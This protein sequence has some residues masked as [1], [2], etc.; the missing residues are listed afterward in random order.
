MTN[1]KNNDPYNLDETQI[2]RFTNKWIKYVTIYNDPCK[3]A[4]L[5][6]S[7]AILVGTVSQ[8]RR[9]GNNIQKYFEYFAK[10]P[11]IEVI[12]KD[13]MIN[14]IENDVWTNTAFITWNWKGLKTPI[15]A[16]MTFIYRGNK[17]VQLH[18]SAMPELNKCLKKISGKP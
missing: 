6:A 8:I 10:L 3:V 9:T 16:R 17:I 1:C 14:H 7:D 18:S 15:I 4:K 2:M 11:N 13:Y 5:F 12:K